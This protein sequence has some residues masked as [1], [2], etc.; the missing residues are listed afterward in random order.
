MNYQLQPPL[1][2]SV[3][4]MRRVSP[5]LA[6][7]RLISTAVWAAILLAALWFAYRA[8]G[9][10]WLAAFGVVAVLF[11][12]HAVLVPLRVRNLGY[13][14]TAN[15][16]VL[17]TGRVWQTVTVIPY[18]RIQFV[19]VQSGPL[20]RA[21][22]LKELEVNTASSTSNSNLPGLPAAEADAL[23]DRLAAR[24]RERMSGL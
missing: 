8:W 3:A 15:E 13:L 10:F 11:V 21:F 16:L 23:R 4:G 18:G 22:G 9:S 19:D 2:T 7:A 6:T 24:A 5:K 1:P 20:T 12:V 14:E 17:S